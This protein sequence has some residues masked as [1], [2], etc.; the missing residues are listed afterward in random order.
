METF[1]TTKMLLLFPAQLL[2]GDIVILGEDYS[3]ADTSTG[4]TDEYA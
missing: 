4:I 3:T 2:T 1:F